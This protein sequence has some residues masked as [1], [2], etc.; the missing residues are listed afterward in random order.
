MAPVKVEILLSVGGVYVQGCQK[1]G[2]RLGN[3]C[4]QK[5][6]LHIGDERYR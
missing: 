1:F 5:S 3:V 4:V 6:D 2:V